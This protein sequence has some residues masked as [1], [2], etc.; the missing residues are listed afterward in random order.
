[1]T[2]REALK[3]KKEFEFKKKTCTT[4]MTGDNKVFH[5]FILDLNGLDLMLDYDAKDKE[6]FGTI[7]NY[8]VRFYTYPSFKGLIKS[9]QK[10]EWCE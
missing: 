3:L 1:M 4:E 7:F 2:L 9:V 8:P 6:W 10:G 5:Y